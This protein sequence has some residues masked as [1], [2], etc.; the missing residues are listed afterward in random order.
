MEYVYVLRIKHKDD[1][2]WGMDH[3]F[4]KEST[5]LKA[6]EEMKNNSIFQPEDMEHFITKRYITKG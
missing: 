6:A 5:A 1:R 2:T 3:L 4:E